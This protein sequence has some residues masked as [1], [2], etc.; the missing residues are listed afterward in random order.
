[1]RIFSLALFK[2]K[3]PII[4]EDGS[5]VRDFVNIYDVVDANMLVMESEEA[6]YQIFNVG[7]GKSITVNEFYKKAD[8]IYDTG[9]EP[10]RDG[11]YRYGDTRHIISDISN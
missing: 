11:Y 4:F 10:I 1:M 2:S 8:S 7:G 9:I 6:D 5:Q 3:R